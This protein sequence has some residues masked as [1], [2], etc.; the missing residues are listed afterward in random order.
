M[1]QR[2]EGSG[3]GALKFADIWDGGDVKNQ[4]CSVG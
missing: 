1:H 4:V 3:H 2:R